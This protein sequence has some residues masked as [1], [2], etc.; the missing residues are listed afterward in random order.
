MSLHDTVCKYCA[1]SP[2]QQYVAARRFIVTV[3]SASFSNNTA[4][5]IQVQHNPAVPTDTRF[6]T[7]YSAQDA[8]LHDDMRP[9]CC[10]S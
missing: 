4:F 2:V 6:K 8:F 9:A 5:C 10:V 7:L 3:T 1:W